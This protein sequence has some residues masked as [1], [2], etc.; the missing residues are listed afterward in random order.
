MGRINTGRVILGG[1]LAGLIIN[2]GEII[3]Q[4]VFA[5]EAEAMMERFGIEPPG[6]LTI[7][8]FVVIGLIMGIA[9]TW[10]YAA[11]RPRLG[12]G[13][14]TAVI[15]G[16]VVWFIGYFLP[17]LGD[18]LVGVWSAWMM[19]VGSAWG[20]VEFTIGA[21]AGGWLYRETESA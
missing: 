5:A 2:V 4:L 18:Y 16:L 10:L 1:L 6:G 9:M 20:L 19:I 15:A 13:P 3:G 21:L 8:I 14:K 7:G 17:L 12:A 11:V